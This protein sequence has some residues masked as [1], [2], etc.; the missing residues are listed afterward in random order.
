MLLYLPGGHHDRG[1]SH[2]HLRPDWKW[3]TTFTVAG[4]WGKSVVAPLNCIGPDPQMQRDRDSEFVS[5]GK[6]TVLDVNRNRPYSSGMETVQPKGPPLA[7][8]RIIDLTTVIFGSYA[9][10]LLADFGAD[11]V[12][13]ESAA[14]DS[15]RRTGPAI[16]PWNFPAAMIARKAEPALAAG[17]SLVLKPAKEKPFSA[18]ALGVLALEAGLPLG[19]L[20]IITGNAK[21]IGLA[22]TKNPIVRKL[23]FTGSTQTG[24]VLMEQ[25]SSTIKKISLELGGNAPLIVFEDADVELAVK[26]IVAAKFR[27]MGQTCVCANR[28]YVHNAIYE[29]VVDRLIQTIDDFKIGNC[30]DEANTHGPLINKKAVD[31]VHTHVVDAIAKGAQLKTGGK[32]PAIGDNYYL[33]TVLTEATDDMLI[34]HEETFGPIAAIFRF[35]DE[36]DVVR[37]ANHTEFGLAAYVFTN[38]YRRV[39]RLSKTIECE[40]LGINTGAISNEV[41]PFGG[42]QKV[43]LRARRLQARH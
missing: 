20:Q 42:H 30:L 38:D 36:A 10:Q 23:T 25:C 13:V 31:K 24:R 7:D 12:K 8:I 39:H 19:V 22:L 21:E 3:L 4:T 41:A 34:C 17:C 33:P 16:T 9:S 2:H 6:H 43:R 11:V 1:L 27:N 18:M 28:I 15:T 14:G 40:M 5:P 29:Q 37:R 35:A 32:Q 26:G